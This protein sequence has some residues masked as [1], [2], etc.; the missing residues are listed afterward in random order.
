MKVEKGKQRQNL[1]CLEKPLGELSLKD[2]K[3]VIGRETG[4]QVKIQEAEMNL[5]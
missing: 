2:K 5:A 1:G 3:R 4:C